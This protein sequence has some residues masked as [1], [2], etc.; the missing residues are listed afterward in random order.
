M[1][2]IVR[3]VGIVGVGVGWGLGSGAAKG[4]NS[5]FA[6]GIIPRGRDSD[7]IYK[8]DAELLAIKS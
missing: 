6:I 3:D 1:P 8:K 4:H 2:R 7:R 5:V